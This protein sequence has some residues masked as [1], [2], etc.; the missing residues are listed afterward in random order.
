MLG[1]ESVVTDLSNFWQRPMVANFGNLTLEIHQVSK[2]E[3]HIWVE[4]LM[5]YFGNLFLER[6]QATCLGSTPWWT[7]LATYSRSTTALATWHRRAP[8]WQMW[9]L[10]WGL[11][12]VVDLSNFNLFGEHPLWTILATYSWSAPW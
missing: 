3:H 12:L 9:T 4:P 7:I 2:F 5:T 6:I 11:P 1:D 10:C 8:W